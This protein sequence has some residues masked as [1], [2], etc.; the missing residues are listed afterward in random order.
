MVMSEEKKDAFDKVVAACA[1]DKTVD[2][3][4]IYEDLLGIDAQKLFDKWCASE[5]GISGLRL[6]LFI[7][8]YYSKIEREDNGIL[9]EKEV[10]R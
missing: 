1:T 10:P 5:T 7:D 8:G 9:E 3:V 6:D 2:E 4:S